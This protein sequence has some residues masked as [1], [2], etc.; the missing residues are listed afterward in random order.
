M[1]IVNLSRRDRLL[2]QTVIGLRYETTPEQL[3]DVLVKLR[4]RLR[5]HPRIVQ[6]TARACFVA[7]GDS[8]LDIEVFA[9]VTT[10]DWVE[11]LRIQEDILLELID[12]I[13]QCGAAMA[14]PSQTLYLGRD[15]RPDSATEAAER[16]CREGGSFPFSL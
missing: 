6:D 7:F 13:E 8:S 11:F 16:S 5:G 10:S 14:F 1:S 3:R 4:E 12:V 2:L 9:Y 15:R